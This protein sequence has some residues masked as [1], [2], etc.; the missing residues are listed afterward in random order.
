LGHRRRK[1]HSNFP[2]PIRPD[3][4]RAEAI[5]AAWAAQDW[6]LLKHYGEIDALPELRF[7]G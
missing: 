2:Q 6:L 7:E 5:R 1:A 3:D 4:T